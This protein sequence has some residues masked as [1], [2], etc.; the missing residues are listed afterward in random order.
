MERSV[1][2]KAPV[3]TKFTGGLSGVLAMLI[4]ASHSDEVDV[5]TDSAFSFSS[6]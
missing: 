6:S 2:S 1:K 3:N 5:Q 4:L